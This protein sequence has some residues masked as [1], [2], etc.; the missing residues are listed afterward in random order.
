MKSGMIVLAGALAMAFT[1]GCSQ[2]GSDDPAIDSLAVD[3]VDTIDAPIDT[4][5]PK[6]TIALAAP[7]DKRGDTTKVRRDSAAVRRD[8]VRIV[9]RDTV[10]IRDTVIIGNT[11]TRRDGRAD[12]GVRAGSRRRR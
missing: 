10:R 2:G 9:I 1:G 3:S 5:P 11:D 4:I 12:T 8:T 7:A 6:D